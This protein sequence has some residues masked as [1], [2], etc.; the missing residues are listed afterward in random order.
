[1]SFIDKW[2]L[3]YTNTLGLS[4]MKLLCSENT[5]IKLD[6]LLEGPLYEEGV[7]RV[8]FASFLKKSSIYL[9]FIIKL[10]NVGFFFP[11]RA[12]FSR[13]TSPSLHGSHQVQRN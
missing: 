10:P 9:C 8:I 1:M 6:I 7:P 13:L 4:D 2:N 3:Y 5:F 12:R 11:M